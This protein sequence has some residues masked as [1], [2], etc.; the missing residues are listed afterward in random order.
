MKNWLSTHDMHKPQEDQE[1]LLNHVHDGIMTGTW[2]YGEYDTHYGRCDELD[3][4]H[5]MD[6]PEL[7][8]ETP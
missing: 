4:T 6:I 8:K 2:R 5:W 7:P 1:V 3:F